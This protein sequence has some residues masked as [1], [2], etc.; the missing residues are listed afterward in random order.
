VYRGGDTSRESLYDCLRDIPGAKDI[1]PST[2]VAEAAL[3]DLKMCIWTILDAGEG[4]GEGMVEHGATKL[5]RVKWHEGWFEGLQRGYR[6]TAEVGKDV[7]VG[8][9]PARDQIRLLL[10]V[11]PHRSRTLDLFEDLHLGRVQNEWLVPIFKELSEVAKKHGEILWPEVT[12][13]VPFWKS[14]T[15]FELFFGAPPVKD[16]NFAEQL[17]EWVFTVKPEDGKNSDR[18][19]L[20]E[21]GFKGLEAKNMVFGEQLPMLEWLKSPSRWL[22]NGA[23]TSRALEGSKRTKFSTYLA[24]SQGELLKDMFSTA[25]PLNKVNP[26]R[27]RSKTRNTVS[28]DWDLYLQMKWLT[29]GV[30]GAMESVFPTT[31]SSKLKQISRWKM[32]RSRMAN[33]VGVPIDQSTFDHVPWM[34]IIISM[35]RY[36]CE[37]AREKAPDPA[38]HE[39]ITEVVIGRI[40]AGS[41]NWE[42]YTWKHVRGLLSGWAWT[43]V[44]GTLMNY[45]EFV[46]IVAVTKGSLP[47]VDAMAFQGDD[48]LLFADSWSQAV[49]WVQTYMR[50]LPVNPGKFFVSTQRTE[51]LRLV[52]TEDRVAGYLG[53]AV[54]SLMYANAWAGGKMSVQSR[55]A[56]W[57]RLVARGGDL[58][59]VREHCIRDIAGFTRASREEVIDLMRTPK[60]VGGLG[61]ESGPCIWRQVRE[62]D[63]LG[64]EQEGR[65]TAATDPERVPR[66]VRRTA[67][68]S[69]ASH[70]GIFSDR[71]VAAGAADGVLMGVQ[72]GSW[73]A[74]KEVDIRIRRVPDST[75]FSLARGLD[76]KDIDFKPPKATIDAMFLPSV[77]RRLLK[78]G[79]ESVM[80]LFSPDDHERVRLKWQAWPRNV[81]FDWV[82]GRI[83][84]VI[85]D[86]WGM[87]P[88]VAAALGDELGWHVWV[89]AGRLSRDSISQ[90]MLWTEFAS[91]KLL[92][93]EREWMGA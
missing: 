23:T 66:S 5:K 91:K 30:E 79:V 31:L 6:M 56:S 14:L 92:R 18:R 86:E 42:S 87:G 61:L 22:A 34:D 74:E 44:L 10:D 62:D 57:S 48:A 58:Q 65:I 27:E 40:R 69:M 17:E 21:A 29:Q 80:T 9:G 13:R 93:D 12:N 36:I 54:P 67:E 52:I 15:S 38:L 90:G 82:C 55:A 60:A 45:I 28:S 47:P 88:V 50:V 16:A 77:L 85:G 81:W 64:K 20:V 51:F 41:V 43:S 68:K 8:Q 75:K 83:K 1:L 19:K 35:I 26:K 89:P 32:W 24:S 63:L 2:G 11:D 39:R 84:G 25:P 76:G 73:N 3:Q 37:R 70:G 53:R 72:G 7:N 33:S 4:V 71:D 59:R 78:R 49:T 46:G